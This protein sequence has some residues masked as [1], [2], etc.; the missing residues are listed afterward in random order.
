MCGRSR[1]I[2]DQCVLIYALN[3][4]THVKNQKLS[5]IVDETIVMVSSTDI[6]YNMLDL[7]DMNLMPEWCT[8]T[9]ASGH[10]LRM[11]NLD[12]EL[13]GG[14]PIYSAFID[15]FGNDVSGNCSKSWNKHWNVYITYRDLLHKLLYKQ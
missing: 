2:N 14:N 4:R 5:K 9:L 3:K 1:R 6:E 12:R 10:A 11:P 8:E 13:A 7:E 15:V